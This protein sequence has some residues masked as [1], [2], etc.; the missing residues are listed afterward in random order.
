MKSCGPCTLCCT[1][2][3]IPELSKAAGTPCRHLGAGCGIYPDRPSSCRVFTCGWLAIEALGEA[4][5][6]DIAGFL[7]R[8]ERDRGHLCIDVDPARP[9]AWRAEPYMSQIRAW[10]RMVEERTGCVLVYAGPE[11]LVVFPEDVIAL[12][13]VGADPTLQV[14]Y[15]RRDG[16]RRP[17]V[18]LLDG[19]R[20]VREWIG[21]TGR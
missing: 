10:S 5:R 12:G 21:L 4:W 15:L 7:I 2:L 13:P 8:D 19:D 9:D 18:R 6:P 11:T 20:T 14:G 1:V 17:F 3:D 16:A